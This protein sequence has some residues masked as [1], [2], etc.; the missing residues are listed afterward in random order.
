MSVQTTYL[1]GCGGLCLRGELDLPR[2]TFREGKHT[3]FRS[4]GDGTVKLRKVE[5]SHIDLILGLGVLSN[6]SEY[7]VLCK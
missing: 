5:A 1:L 3:S 6:H 2:W 4:M 7:D